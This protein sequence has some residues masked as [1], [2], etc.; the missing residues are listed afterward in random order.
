MGKVY[1]GTGVKIAKLPGVQATL[2]YVAAARLVRAKSLA[3]AHAKTGKY[4]SSLEVV[5]TPGKKGVMDRAIVANDPA[6]LAI[7][8]GHMTRNGKHVPG[9]YILNRAIGR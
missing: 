4:A 3:A 1:K 8:L 5:T 9:Q 7:E 2:G 6:A